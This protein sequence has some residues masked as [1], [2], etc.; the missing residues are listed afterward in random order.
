MA[1]QAEEE[2]TMNN[3][4]LR[5]PHLDLDINKSE[6]LIGLTEIPNP[7]LENKQHSSLQ[8]SETASSFRGHDAE[9]SWTWEIAGALFIVVRV[10]LLIGF[11]VY[12]KM[13]WLIPPGNTRFRPIPWS[14][15]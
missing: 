11:L 7:Q 13:G 10:T 4:N 6:I 3:K 5:M 8:I 12:A 1:A 14:P 2:S 15:S 9:G